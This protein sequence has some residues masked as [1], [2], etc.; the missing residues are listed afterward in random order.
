MVSPSNQPSLVA[1]F[2]SYFV[3]G[4]LFSLPLVFSLYVLVWIVQTVDGWLHHLVPYSYLSQPS[5]PFSIPGIG[6]LVV[7]FAFVVIGMITKG[8]FG[9]IILRYSEQI[10]SKMP[11]VRT[12]Y[13][14]TKQISEAVLQSQSNSFR[15]VGLM[16]YPRPGVWVLCFVTGSTKGEVQRKTLKDMVNV[17]VPTTPNPTSGFLLFVPRNQ[18]IP[19]D[20][21]VEAGIK[22]VVS[23]GMI[24]PEDVKN[25]QEA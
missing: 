14:T 23:A 18:I 19:L 6:L 21:T 8:L 17:F 24:I 15:E 10:F 7:V 1:R 3:S 13:S 5:F 9:K 25:P 22:M 4:L 11:I 20:M 16:E 2:R 12:V